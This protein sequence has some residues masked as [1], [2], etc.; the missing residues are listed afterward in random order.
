MIRDPCSSSAPADAGSEYLSAVDLTDSEDTGRAVS[1]VNQD[2][3]SPQVATMGGSYSGLSP[4]IIL[5]NFILKQV[6]TL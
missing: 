1:V 4:M 2:Q 5:N 3:H 6:V